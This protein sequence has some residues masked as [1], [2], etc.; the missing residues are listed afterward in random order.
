M[1][2]ASFMPGMRFSGP[3]TMVWTVTAV[4]VWVGV[5]VAPPASS[6]PLPLV[7]AATATS[8][9]KAQALAA[10][11]GA[12]PAL[13][14][15]PIVTGLDIPWDLFFT[16]ENTMIFNQRA[17]GLW[18]RNAGGAVNQVSADFSD[19]Y[20]EG[21]VGLM[22]M[23]MD[24]DFAATGN[25]L[26]YTCQ[27]HRDITGTDIRVIRWRINPGYTAATRVGGPLVAGIKQ[28]ATNHAGCR[29]RFDN[30]KLLYVTTGD[31]ASG[32]APQDLGTLNGK[33]LRVDRDG[34]PPATNPFAGSSNS[35]ARLV[36]TRG[37]RNPQGLSLR[38]GTNELWSVEQGTDR[39][40]EI[41]RLVPGGN[42]GWNPVRP[43]SN[44]YDQ[45]TPMTDPN[46]PDPR[47]AVF[48]S[49]FLRSPCPAARGSRARIGGA[50]T[51]RS[52]RWP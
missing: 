31:S 41:N 27:G 40:D 49:V 43:P 18:A 10:A 26:F 33:V 23:V 22:G 24:P 2:Q 17:G 39:D 48:S 42:Y 45:G 47:A 36:F 14:V 7:A 16:P 28:S 29:L 30:D 37:H 46:V 52:W 44:A 3:K 11:Q 32:P 9:G 15:T 50:G 4:V 12:A 34:N 21:E 13:T 51:A 35:N 5:A 25:R 6:M 8:T 1:R 38:P 20:A 19:L